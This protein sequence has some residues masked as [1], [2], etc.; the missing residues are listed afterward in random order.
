MFFPIVRGHISSPEKEPSRR[1]GKKQSHQ[2]AVGQ[3]RPVVTSLRA[4]KVPWGKTTLEAA[5]LSPAYRTLHFREGYAGDGRL[6]N[7]RQVAA[8]MQDCPV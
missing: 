3:L 2:Q 5:L 6:F 4:Q 8:R 1:G 7:I